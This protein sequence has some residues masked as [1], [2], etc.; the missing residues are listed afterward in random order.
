MP[1]QFQEGKAQVSLK[2]FY[3]G[4]LPS[5]VIAAL[6]VKLAEVDVDVDV[7]IYTDTD[8]FV[9]NFSLYCNL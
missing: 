3:I 9:T 5:L 8:D 2:L 7:N 6:P 4:P 1:T